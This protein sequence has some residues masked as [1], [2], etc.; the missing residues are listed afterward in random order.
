M[1]APSATMRYKGY[2]TVTRDTTIVE[3]PYEAGQYFR[4]LA[5]R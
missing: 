1:H 3:R 2:Q 4:E 5:Y